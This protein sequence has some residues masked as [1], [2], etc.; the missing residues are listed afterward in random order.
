[1]TVRTTRKSVT[2]AAP[3]R[4]IGF[5]EPLPAGSYEVETDEE[6][7]EGAAHTAFRRTATT[8]RVRK[9]SVT[10]HH[11]IDPA[12]L[13]AALERDRQAALP[14]TPT[15]EAA[16]AQAAPSQEASL[17]HPRWVSLWVRNRPP[18]G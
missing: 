16:S 7:L 5:D 6:M 14:T 11:S 13:A 18:T 10:E 9:G 4:L 3:F 1:M 12:D 17:R 2:F 8:L 15:P